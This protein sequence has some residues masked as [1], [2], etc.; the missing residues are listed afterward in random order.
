MF[1]LAVITF[2]EKLPEEAHALRIV[3]NIPKVCALH[4]RKPGYS[5]NELRL[6]IEAL[7]VSLRGKIRLHDHFELCEE[8]GLQGVHLNH[9]RPAP[10]AHIRPISASC[11]NLQEVIDY[12]KSCDYVFLSPIFD[13]ISKQGYTGKFSPETLSEAAKSGIIDQQVFALGGVHAKYIPM[14][15]QWGF[16]GAAMLG[17]IWQDYRQNPD[18]DRFSTHLKNLFNKIDGRPWI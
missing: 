14:L 16:G 8:Y 13:S 2:P 15:R 17:E 10:P 12:K 18:L 7:P 1:R 3:G 9:R 4:L 5:E 11:H 6:L